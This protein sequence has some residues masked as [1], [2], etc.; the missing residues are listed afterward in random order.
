M[1][2]LSSSDSIPRM[3]ESLV[4]ADGLRMASGVELYTYLGSASDGHPNDRQEL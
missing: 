1:F 2:L 3:Q 4:A